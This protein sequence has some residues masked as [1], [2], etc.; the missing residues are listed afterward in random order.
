MKKVKV[1][2]R[3]GETTSV[4]P[5]SNGT[6]PVWFADTGTVEFIESSKV[7]FLNKY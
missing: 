5:Q 7:V 2:N 3:I 4:I 6:Y 1:E